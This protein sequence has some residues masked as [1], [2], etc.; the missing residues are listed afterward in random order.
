[1]IVNTIND[2]DNNDKRFPSH[3]ELG[4]CRTSVIRD[5]KNRYRGF[6]LRTAQHSNHYDKIAYS[7]E[8]I[9]A[10]HF[11]STHKTSIAADL[12]EVR[13]HSVGL[14]HVPDHCWG[15]PQEQQG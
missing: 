12:G 10:M 11:V 3:D 14:H 2:N 6:K 1:M 9:K 5:G 4:T 8:Q 15:P 7:R 13:R